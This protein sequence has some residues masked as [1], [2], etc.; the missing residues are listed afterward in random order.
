MAGP[1]ASF[2][3]D[4]LQ[5]TI[6]TQTALDIRSRCD[7]RKFRAPAF[8]I[9]QF[10]A[11]TQRRAALRTNLRRRLFIHARERISG[12]VPPD[13]VGMQDMREQFRSIDHPQTWPA[14]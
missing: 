2:N 4:G 6:A 9:P 13:A 12:S 5:Q 8:K 11:A 3:S 14:E 1:S 7:G 10:G